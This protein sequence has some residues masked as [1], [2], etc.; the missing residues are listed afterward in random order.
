MWNRS[1]KRRMGLVLGLG[2]ALVA[3]LGYV[4]AKDR[5]WFLTA[6][7]QD[8]TAPLDPPAS[9][10]RAAELPAGSDP[11]HAPQSERQASREGPS[12]EESRLAG[13][14]PGPAPVPGGNPD[15]VADDTAGDLPEAP[16][17]DVVRVA[18]DGSAVVAGQAAPGARVTVF[19]DADPIA[20]T[21]ADKSGSFVALFDAPPAPKPRA[22]TLG[23]DGAEA[24]SAAVVMLLPPP[25]PVADAGANAGPHS[26]DG[27]GLPAG[28]AEGAAPAVAATAIVR[29]DAVEVRGTAPDRARGGGVTLASIGY[30]K[31]GDVRLGGFASAGAD[32]RLYV[33]GTFAE[34]A[35][36]APDGSWQL[37]LG[38]VDAG[39]YRLRIDE[40]GANGRVESRVETPFQRDFPEL[41]QDLPA[42]PGAD[43]P[44]GAVVPGSVTVQPGN[45]LWTLARIHYGE[46][47]RYTQI[48]TANREMIRNPDLIYPGQIFVLPEDAAAD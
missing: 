31:A 16:R 37:R 11:G 38:D 23:S 12:D 8:A 41:P 47:V 22:L 32:L 10:D 40:I 24:R 18:S 4:A 27:A 9:E 17:F 42:V 13:L 19:A 26:G 21:T 46:G 14:G 5:L 15:A 33:D 36:A 44:E 39:L 2:A 48:F 3:S 28:R 45:D 20:E 29:A 30:G 25:P 7:R 35:T 43:L 1:G 34:A 6:P